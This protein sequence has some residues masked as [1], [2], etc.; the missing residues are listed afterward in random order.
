M[1]NQITIMDGI[2]E[3]GIFE[4]DADAWVSSRTITELFNEPGHEKT[5]SDVLKIIRRIDENLAGD[6][7]FANFK[8][9]SFKN[10]GKSYPEYHMSRKAYTMVIMGFNGPEALKYKVQYIEAFEA[11]IQLI[12]TRQISKGGFR[13]MTDS[14]Q[15]I[16]AENYYQEADMINTVVLG[17]T[18]KKYKEIHGVNTKGKTRD[19][20]AV[21]Q[22]NKLD[23]SQKMNG[24]LIAAGLPFKQR[25]TIIMQ[26]FGD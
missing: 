11:M 22:L 21:E 24:R 3:L 10:R 5:H 17:M 23:E 26:S 20:V 19:A 7:F 12:K 8:K 9:K 15:A 4:K 6:F 18:A 14:I 2:P 13:F 16:G 1:T 25:K